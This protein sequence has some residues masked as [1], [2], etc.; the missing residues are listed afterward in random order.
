[1]SPAAG[2]APSA[3][4]KSGEDGQFGGRNAALLFGQDPST[5]SWVLSR[6]EADLKL[7]FHTQTTST[8]RKLP[9]RHPPGSGE[10]RP[11]VLRPSPF[12]WGNQ[13]LGASASPHG[14]QRT[15]G[16]GGA[17]PCPW[18]GGC[19]RELVLWGR[20]P[21]CIP[22]WVSPCP[23]GCVKPHIPAMGL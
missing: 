21:C 18:R 1:M 23:G 14:H 7:C 4:R 22:M 6:A 10:P 12:P 20:V 5:R 9:P 13:T 11:A 17:E 19:K 8:G 16:R 2:K 15:R 3:P